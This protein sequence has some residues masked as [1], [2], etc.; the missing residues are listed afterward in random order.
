ML[1]HRYIHTYK[2]PLAGITC[3]QFYEVFPTF[4]CFEEGWSQRSSLSS[5]VSPSTILQ[6]NHFSASTQTDVLCSSEHT[7]L[8]N[9][10]KIYAITILHNVI[11]TLSC[12]Q[13]PSLKLRNHCTLVCPSYET[14]NNK[15]SFSRNPELL[16]RNLNK[17][18]LK[19]I[20]ELIYTLNLQNKV[21]TRQNTNCK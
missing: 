5:E 21:Y 10:S 2:M 17:N 16:F 7:V 14:K 1:L 15:G 12:F 11:P 19:K 4:Y 8:F 6:Q 20:L 3:H 18:C 13:K 9:T